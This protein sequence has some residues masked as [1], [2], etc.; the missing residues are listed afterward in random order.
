M[1]NTVYNPNKTVLIATHQ[2]N[3]IKEADYIYNLENGKILEHGTPSELLNTDSDIGGRYERFVASANK[4]EE[5]PKLG[6]DN[7]APES[8]TELENDTEE[9]TGSEKDAFIVKPEVAKSHDFEVRPAAN[10]DTYIQ[11][12]KNGPGFIIFA[13]LILLYLITIGCVQGRVQ[14]VFVNA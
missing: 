8:D 14:S 9:E 13:A 11:T 3:Y 5:K 10:F 12:I 2:L 1:F 4:K 7:T 6:S